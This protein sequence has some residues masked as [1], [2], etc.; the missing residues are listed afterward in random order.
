LSFTEAVSVAHCDS[1]LLLNGVPPHPHPPVQSSPLGR[2]VQSV[3]PLQD[4]SY[5]VGSIV[6]QLVAPLLAPDDA[7]PDDAPPD[8]LAPDE[9]APDDDVSPDDAE[10]DEDEVVSGPP[11]H[12]MTS[13]AIAVMTRRRFTPRY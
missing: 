6:T 11:V 3:S 12:A 1:A 4:V 10:L 5:L 13:A 7:A 2:I 9:E 8:E